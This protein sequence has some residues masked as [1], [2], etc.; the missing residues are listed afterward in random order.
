VTPMMKRASFLVVLTLAALSASARAGEKVELRAG[1]HEGY[2]RIAIQWPTPVTYQ[3]KI[4]GPNLVIHF[5][6]PFTA[7]LN[8]VSRNLDHY[9]ANAS[10]SADGT[11]ITAKLLRPVELKTETVD[12][13]II[14]IDLVQKIET[15]AA[16]PNA[17][18]LAKGKLIKAPPPKT[19]VAQAAPGKAK[20]EQL[21]S[22]EAP[23]LTVVPPAGIGP[24]A[25]VNPAAGEAVVASIA[26]AETK[27]PE[28]KPAAP[29]AAT[30][31]IPNT[32]PAGTLAPQLITESGQ[33][34]LRFDW[35]SPVAA[36]IYRRN[37]A[38]WLVFAGATKFDLD[39]LRAKS[40]GV[41]SAIDVVPAGAGSALRLVVAD[42]LN[43][44]VRR[45]GNS[46]IVDLKR[47]APTPDAPISVDPRPSANLPSVDLHVH[48]AAAPLSIKDPVMGDTLVVVPVGE[49]G[50]GIDAA[51][52]FVDFRLL[53]SVQGIVIR[54]NTDDL[55]V[56]PDTDAVQVTR[57]HGLALSNEHD[58]LLG[59][60]PTDLHRLFD[61]S[62]WNGP[63]TES[64]IERRKKLERAAA[65][66]APAARTVPRLDLARFY[67]AHL[68]A[69]EA[70]G[71]LAQI[72][73]DDPA[74]ATDRGIQ[75]LKGAACYLADEPDCASKQLNLA[76]FDNEP[77]IALWR[78]AL[79]ADLADWNTAA[80]EFTNSIGVISTYPKVLRDRFA[81][82]AAEAM[83][84]TDHGSAAGPLLDTVLK[85][86]PSASDK[87][88]A[89]YLSGRREQELG[90]LEPA[91]EEWVK[92][93]ASGDR[94]ARA[95]ALYARAMALY[96]N[97]Q[98]SRLD[99]I[100]SLDALRFSWRGDVFEFMLLRQ[101]GELQLA[102]G[103][104]DGGIESLHEAAIYFP[105][106]PA[107]KDVAKE[108][109]DSFANLYLSNK[110]DDV[111]PVKAL[112]L[113]TEF[114]DLE[115]AGD[116]HDQIV[117]KL[118]DRLVAV[119]L[120][121]QATTLLD[122]QVKNHLSGRDKARGATQLALLRLMN[123][124]P[125][126]AIAALDVD[127]GSDIPQDLAR[128]RQELRARALTD[129]NKVPD[130]LALLQNDNSVDA[131]RLRA[132]IFWRQKDW[133]NAAKMFG[134]LAG[135]PPAQGPLGVDL[136]RIL[137]AWASALTLDSDQDGIDKLRK[138]WSPAI[139]GT[140]TAQAFD[141]ITED[142]NAGV[143]GGG[144][145]A[146]IA[147]RV[148]EIGNLQ[149]FMAAY[150]NR[151]ASDGLNAAVN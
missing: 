80:R 150:R 15:L 51:R 41:L 20:P 105:D 121:D 134:E 63:D 141:L 95:R 129:L 13:N 149:S 85:D 131:A 82:I 26:P 43:P 112:A 84:E 5:A 48:Q 32:S 59:G 86:Q 18:M 135:A 49:L 120:L 107:S 27:S 30:A 100:N 24:E 14:A 17:Q 11:T 62:A 103:D 3:A 98:V 35:P 76:T 42:G 93:A 39:S 45:A 138:D 65:D 16:K 77:E 88:M 25:A 50:R 47:V 72:E 7:Q 52:S 114:Q 136:S 99:T 89:Q 23:P 91:L 28:T 68:F 81:L 75:A 97:K 127:V 79:A 143:S 133:K 53:E 21:A 126:A 34:S 96:G 22:Q 57:P 87:A 113:Y 38:L 40:Q 125:D 67:F 61:F 119:D 64:F 46:W 101:L 148:A 36:A 128:Q 4:E 142:A 94:K 73:H 132:D 9:L 71:V 146:D 58:R 37:S 110:A 69:A 111:P 55:V 92:V 29:Q 130:A 60:V 104:V 33:T 54:P 140:Q 124:Q 145:A 108:A 117:R 144:N 78:G 90:Q 83:L 74:S 2:G 1:E 106:Y 118:I 137:L 31:V 123:R 151:L 19:E 10:Q 70:L 66:A 44:S 116:R 115:P 122:D 6:R 109:A 56:L 139:A 12:R 8:I 102:E 147:T